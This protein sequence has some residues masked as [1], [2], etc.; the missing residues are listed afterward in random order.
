MTHDVIID[1]T[2]YIPE[3]KKSFIVNG[4][5]YGS[6]EVYL[7]NIRGELAHKYYEDAKLNGIGSYELL[8]EITKF[9]EFCEKYF[10]LRY[11]NENHTYVYIIEN[12]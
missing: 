12:Q 4:I 9:D 10:H 3:N 5:D 8:D 1:G 2:R 7:F 11:D 6:F